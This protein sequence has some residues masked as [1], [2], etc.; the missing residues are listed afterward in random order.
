MTSACLRT[1]L[2]LVPRHGR[3][4]WKALE[5][6]ATWREG[7]LRGAGACAAASLLIGRT[8][9][10]QL[11]RDIDR[12]A[13]I[14]GVIVQGRYDVVCPAR[15]AWD[16]HRAWPAADLRI[17]AD[18]GHSVQGDQPVKLIEILRGVLAR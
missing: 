10:G 5:A 3:A 17:V 4:A 1:W 8:S 12:L 18:A 11:L 14:P 6:A 16:L 7:D 9:L 13:G 15:S 2:P